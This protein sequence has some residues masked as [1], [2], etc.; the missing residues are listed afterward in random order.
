[1]NLLNVSNRP[2]AVDPDSIA[3]LQTLLHRQIQTQPRNSL[4]CHDI[5]PWQRSKIVDWMVDVFSSYELTDE[6]LMMAVNLLDSFWM[7]A[8]T[9]QTN[10]DLHLIGIACVFMASKYEEVQAIPLKIVEKKLAH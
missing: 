4:A 9:K 8:S 5:T 7:Q 1:M 3:I 2:S 6:G 10:A